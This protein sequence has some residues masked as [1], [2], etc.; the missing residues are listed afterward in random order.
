MRL[1]VKVEKGGLQT[2]II[3]TAINN[4]LTILLYNNGPYCYIIIALYTEPSA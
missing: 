3:T 2:I 4:K 1:I